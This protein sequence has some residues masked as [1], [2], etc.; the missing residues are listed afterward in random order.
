PARDGRPG[1]GG[2]VAGRARGCGAGGGGAVA[3]GA[4]LGRRGGA[5]GGDRAGSVARGAAVPVPGLA[6]SLER[7]LD[8]AERGRGTTH[9]NPV[10]GVVVVRDG[11]VVGE[12]WHERAGG[13]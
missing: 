7:A 1:A 4:V 10:V 13:P 2:R 3:P 9:P 8:L 11:E 12:G 5:L 6:V